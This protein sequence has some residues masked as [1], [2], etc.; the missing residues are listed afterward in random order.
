MQYS[1]PDDFVLA[2]GKTF[3]V[4]EFVNL[5]F[6]YA[7]IKIKWIGKGIEEKGIDI[8]NKRILVKVDKKYYRPNEVD[9]LRGDSSKAKKLLNWKCQISFKDLVKEMVTSDLKKNKVIL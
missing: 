8:K 1:K 6:L 5:A 4:R 2:T 3:S 7:G 9:Y